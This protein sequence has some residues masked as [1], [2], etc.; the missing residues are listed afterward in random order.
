MSVALLIKG[1]NR[2][3]SLVPVATEDTYR[4]V[5]Q[6]GAHALGLEWVK[7]MQFGVEVT[8]DDLADVLDE[9]RMLRAWFEA[10]SYPSLC[11]RLDFVV[12][13]LKA[14]RFDA[15]ETASIG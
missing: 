12:K 15:G 8:R 6:A 5:W 1:A 11:E 9:L 3:T 13:G 7:A 14:V 10:S 2:E 4:T